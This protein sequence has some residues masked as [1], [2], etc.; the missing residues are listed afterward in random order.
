MQGVSDPDS[1]DSSVRSLQV[2]DSRWYSFVFR[3]PSFGNRLACVRR[4]K[5]DKSVESSSWVCSFGGGIRRRFVVISSISYGG[6]LLL[7]P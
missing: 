3:V 5:V 6:E 1:V 4:G 7:R 2:P